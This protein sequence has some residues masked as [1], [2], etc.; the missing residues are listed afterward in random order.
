MRRILVYPSHEMNPKNNDLFGDKKL[1]IIFY[2]ITLRN[3]A[4]KSN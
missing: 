3:Y 4:K 2:L 1:L